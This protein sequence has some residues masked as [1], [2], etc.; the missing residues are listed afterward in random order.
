MPQEHVQETVNLRK[1]S[2][3]DG[4]LGAW[5]AYVSYAWGADHLKPISKTKD[6]WFKVGLTLIDSLDTLWLMGQRDQRAM[7]AFG[8]GTILVLINA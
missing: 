6:D 8:Q 5:E 1:Q 4:T 2:V 7:T 3:I